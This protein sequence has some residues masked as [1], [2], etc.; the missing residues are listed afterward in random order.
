MISSGHYEV[1]IK[2]ARDSKQS[3]GSKFSVT[4]NSVGVGICGLLPDNGPGGVGVEVFGTNFGSGKGGSDLG[5]S[6]GQLLTPDGATPELQLPHPRA[7]T[8]EMLF[9]SPQIGIFLIP[10]HSDS[11]D[12][13]PRRAEAGSRAVRTAR[14]N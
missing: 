11:H 4:D 3:L 6:R 13:R 1:K 10:S 2:R 7:L 12:V 5:R 8:Q 9:S 14:A